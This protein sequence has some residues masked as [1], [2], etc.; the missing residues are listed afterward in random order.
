MKEKSKYCG[1]VA[2]THILSIFQEKRDP[3]I[4]DNYSLVIN[5][6]NFLCCF[7]IR[8]AISLGTHIYHK[9]ISYSLV[10]SF[11]QTVLLD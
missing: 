10:L 11:F 7:L 5:D 1:A 4:Y 9:I 2:T 8:N 3:V 6:D